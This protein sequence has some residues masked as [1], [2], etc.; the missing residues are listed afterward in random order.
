MGQIVDV[1]WLY[2][3]HARGDF[4]GRSDVDLLYVSD[5]VDL[6]AT[7]AVGVRPKEDSVVSLYSWHEIEAMAEYGSLFL[8][9]LRIDG[10]PVY[11]SPQCTGRLEKRLSRL[12]QY[13]LASRDLL[14]F[15][16]VVDDVL[17]SLSDGQASLRYELSVLGTVVRHA[18]ILGCALNGSYCFSRIEPVEKMIS[19]GALPKHWAEE[20]AGLYDYRLLVDG[21]IQGCATPSMALAQTWC[22]RAEALLDV[23]GRR[24]CDAG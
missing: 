17:M 1:I 5:R 8:H 21:R 14:G 3:S 13:Q 20:F 6:A 10:Q 18:A 22:S 16:R 11:E 15:R 2:G 4:D 9:H 19:L 7:A 24:I 12:G 23:L